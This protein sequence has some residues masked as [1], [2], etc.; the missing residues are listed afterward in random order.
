[1]IAVDEL[2]RRA[3][4]LCDACNGPGHYDKPTTHRNVWRK[5]AARI[6][7]HARYMN[8]SRLCRLLRAVGIA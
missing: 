3:R 6:A 2:E 4:E 5:K 1:M 7:E 8:A